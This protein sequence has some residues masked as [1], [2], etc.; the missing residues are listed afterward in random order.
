MSPVPGRHVDQQV[1][2]VSPVHVLE[3]L[4]DGPVEDQAHAT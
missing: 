3:E 2:E 1:V 4:L